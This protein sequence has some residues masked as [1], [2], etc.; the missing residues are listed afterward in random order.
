MSGSTVWTLALV[1]AELSAVSRSSMD[2][3]TRAELAIVPKTSPATRAPV[4]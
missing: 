3:S 1:G 4:F 2:E